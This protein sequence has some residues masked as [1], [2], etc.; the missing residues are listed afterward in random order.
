[1]SEQERVTGTVQWFDPG[2]H[3][4]FITPEDGPDV[5][6]HQTEIREGHTLAGGVRVEFTITQDPRGPKATDVVR[7]D[8]YGENRKKSPNL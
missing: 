1:M 5:F 7:L 3:F 8:S 4:G 6:V 2:R